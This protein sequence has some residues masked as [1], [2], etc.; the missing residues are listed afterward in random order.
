[1]G[2]SKQ[3]LSQEERALEKT[4]ADVRFL[5]MGRC[6]QSAAKRMGELRRRLEAHLDTEGRLM[7]IF[8]NRTGDPALLALRLRKEH[9]KIPRRVE[10]ASGAITQ[11][12]SSRALYE[13]DR[14]S[15]ALEAHH[16][17]ED[18]LLHPAL[19]DL[20]PD[21]LDWESLRYQLIGR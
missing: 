17:T 16:E 10:A 15:E 11:W 12:D 7:P 18:E 6:F 14:L 8:I 2:A 3:L 21:D 4:L 19:D 1:M 5:V 13:L 9:D 20:V